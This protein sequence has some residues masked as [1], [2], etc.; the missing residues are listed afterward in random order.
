M[1]KTC[2]IIVKNFTSSVLKTSQISTASTATPVFNVFLTRFSHIFT[3]TFSQVNY[4]YTQPKRVSFK[5]LDSF[6]ST[7]ST[8]PLKTNE[9]NKGF[10]L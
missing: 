8:V 2:V 10:I 5:V 6:K 7:F 3:T 9:L 4:I 1:R